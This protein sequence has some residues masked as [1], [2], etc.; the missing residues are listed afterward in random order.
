MKVVLLAGGTG[1]IG[2]RLQSMLR[3]H[4]YE[5]RILTRTPRVQGQF[6]WNPV[7]GTI[8]GTALQGVDAVVNL[9][10]SGIADGRWT[11]ARK[12]DI[13]D[14]RVQGTQT[15][16]QAFINSKIQPNVYISA[17][18]IGYYGNSGERLMV[19]TDPP[20]EGF[21]SESCI[22]WEQAIEKVTATGIRT[23]GLRIG[24]VL[25]KEGGALREIIKP[26]YAGMGAYFADG[27]A[28]YS[29]IHR[30]DVCRMIIWA[31]EHP[32]VEGIY[33]AVAPHPE[34]NIDLV[35]MTAKTM[36]R[37]AV[38][39]PAPAFALRLMLGEM[40]AVVLNSNRVSAEKA[41]TAGF[42]FQY[43]QLEG[44]LKSIFGKF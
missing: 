15:L 28:W 4:G 21:L 20:G 2:T 27:Q 41:L 30:D 12:R 19:E 36:R 7:V 39:V 13:I 18:A 34:R 23:V 37:P 25:A 8:D 38:F 24:V 29:W 14:S 11:A 42:T 16:L 26:L 31:M 17:A 43:P 6:A 5:V 33:N 35:K 9:A 32:A 10:G 22:H 40:S 44:A 3:E 1:L